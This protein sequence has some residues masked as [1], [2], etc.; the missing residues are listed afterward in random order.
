MRLA[1]WLKKKLRD[2]G[3]EYCRDF[4]AEVIARECGR[5]HTELA[6]RLTSS[7]VDYVLLNYLNVR[8][9]DPLEA[10]PAVRPP[11]T[12]RT[13]AAPVV[14]EEEAAHP[15]GPLDAERRI[16]GLEIAVK[17]LLAEVTRQGAEI[18]TLRS[19]A[20]RLG[21]DVLRLHG[22]LKR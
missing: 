13:Y 17:L 20:H 16:A 18:G 19:E 21:A 10:D 7:H 3:T 4:T 1:L 14:V 5:D 22:I 15:A 11:S 9:T 6:P 12:T 2:H 8:R